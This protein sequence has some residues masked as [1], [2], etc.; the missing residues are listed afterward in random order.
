MNC[1]RI[2]PNLVFGPD[3]RSEEEFVQLRALKITAILNLQ[4]DD[5]VAG[6]LL[7]AK[8]TAERHG[9]VFCN[10]P[11]TDFDRL[12]LRRKLPACVDRLKALLDAG[13]SVY[14]H[15]TAG[16]NRSPTVSAAYLHW[17]LDWPIARR[18]AFRGAS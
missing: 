8:N 9:F 18:R 17:Y 6:G 1:A 2:L 12:E 15:C 10:M 14:V 16:V 13:H 4:A 7:P 11:V 5:E 3:T